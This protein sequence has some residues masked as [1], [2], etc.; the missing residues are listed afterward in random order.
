MEWM[1]EYFE[2]LNPVLQALL[3]TLFTWSVT[4]L[5]ASAVF[6]TKTFSLP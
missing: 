6:L 1:V 4:A 3:A 2:G 5:G